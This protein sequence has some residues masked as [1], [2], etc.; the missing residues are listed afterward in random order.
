MRDCYKRIKGADN[1]IDNRLVTRDMLLGLIEINMDA[2]D[3]GFDDAKKVARE[4]VSKILADPVLMAWY[5]K[6]G[7]RYFPPVC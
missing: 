6:R 5:D 4:R 3:L 7:D 2:V 1:M